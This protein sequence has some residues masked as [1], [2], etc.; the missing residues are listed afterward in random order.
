MDGESGELTEEEDAKAR[1]RW[2]DWDE[3]GGEKQ[4]VHSGDRMKPVERND[5][6]YVTRMMLMAASSQSDER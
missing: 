3:V 6:L 5:Q 1:Q 4:E 2:T